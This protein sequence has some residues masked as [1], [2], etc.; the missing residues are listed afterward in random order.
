MSRV[1]TPHF[2][3]RG[4]TRCEIA[5]GKIIYKKIKQLQYIS[6]HLLKRCY[7]KKKKL[8]TNDSSTSK[9]NEN[10]FKSNI[11]SLPNKLHLGIPIKLNI[12]LAIK[13]MFKIHCPLSKKIDS[14]SNKKYAYTT[15]RYQLNKEPWAERY[16]SK[17]N[18]LENSLHFCT[19][20]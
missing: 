18:P 19:G 1:R 6:S 12:L 11:S 5:N 10:I 15:I 4:C 7:Y 14:L 8:I 20:Y 17:Q 9:N 2:L 16:V 3:I 13:V